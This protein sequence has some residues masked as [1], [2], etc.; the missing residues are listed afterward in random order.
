VTINADDLPPAVRKRLGLAGKGRSKPKPSS[1]GVGL[2]M[3]CAGHCG[4]GEAFPTALAWEKHANVTG[5]RVWSIDLPG[6]A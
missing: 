1:A 4:C 6:P 3:P 2:S 5:C